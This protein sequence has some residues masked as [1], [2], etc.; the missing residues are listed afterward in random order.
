MVDGHRNM[1]NEPAKPGNAPRRHGRL[2]RFLSVVLVLAVLATIGTLAYSIASPVSTDK[3]TEFYILGLE[4]NADWYPSMF[5]LEDGEVVL[6]HYTS[7]D[8]YQEREEGFGRVTLGVVNREQREA[9]YEI[10][11]RIGGSPVD[12]WLDE[13]QVARIRPVTLAHGESR[14]FAVAFAPG[15]VCGLT[16]LSAPA[17]EGDTQLAVAAVDH[18]AAGDYVH[19]GAPD[20]GHTEFVQIEAVSLGESTITLKTALVHDHEEDERVAERQKVE[21]VLYM[22]G[23][24]YFDDGEAPHLWIDVRPF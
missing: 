12:F 5:V 1:M 21:F 2:G 7:G 16:S 17:A 22:D 20:G 15:E 23:H 10:E 3:F 13:E 9:S 11:V 19:L 6:V 8:L 4:G 24:A 18:L 14:E